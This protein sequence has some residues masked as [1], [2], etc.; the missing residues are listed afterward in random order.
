[1]T[2]II[3]NRENGFSSYSYAINNGYSIGDSKIS[4]AGICY[5]HNWKVSHIEKPTLKS[6]GKTKKV[7]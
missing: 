5:T 3:F 6:T 7:R 1:M 4:G 2:S